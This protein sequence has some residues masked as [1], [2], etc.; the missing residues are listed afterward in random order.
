MVLVH[1]MDLLRVVGTILK[2][3]LC[4]FTTEVGMDLTG[5]REALFPTLGKQCVGGPK[6]GPLDLGAGAQIWMAGEGLLWKNGFPNWWNGGPNRGD[7][8]NRRG[9]PFG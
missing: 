2:Q 6:N 4:F 1:Q 3:S 8:T 7:G 9:N 5:A